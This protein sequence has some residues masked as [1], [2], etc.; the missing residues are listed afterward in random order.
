MTKTR[1]CISLD[2][3]LVRMADTKLGMPLSTFL[4]NVLKETINVS[5]EIDEV[6]EEIQKHENTLT[7]LRA[8]LCRLEKQKLL[9]IEFQTD[10]DK[11]MITINRIHNTHG[12]VGENQIENVAVNYNVESNALIQYCKDNGLHVVKGFEPLKKVKGNL[13]GSLR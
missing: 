13:G 6:K 8:K 10:Y 4:Y 1:K 11:C 3:D 9:D 2:E 7:G 12:C 5:D